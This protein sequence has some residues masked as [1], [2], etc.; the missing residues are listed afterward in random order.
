MSEPFDCAPHGAVRTVCVP[1]IRE[2]I[3]IGDIDVRPLGEP[4]Q[5]PKGHIAELTG[6]A[7]EYDLKSVG[8][9]T[10]SLISRQAGW[11]RRASSPKCYGVD[12]NFFTDQVKSLFEEF[13]GVSM[14]LRQILQRAPK[15]YS[16]GGIHKVT[17]K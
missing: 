13:E 1:D 10:Q 9:N 8:I 11:S 12:A 2:Q 14:G 3:F 4:Q 17:R 5:K 15:Q 6:L 7:P 16:I